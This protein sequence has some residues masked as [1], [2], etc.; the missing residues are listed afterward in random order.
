M[1]SD[2]TYRAATTLAR[3]DKSGEIHRSFTSHAAPPGVL[4][5]RR[6][7]LESQLLELDGQVHVDDRN[8]GRE[9][10]YDGGEIQDAAH[11]G[12]RERLADFLR[13]LPGY[14]HNP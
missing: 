6:L 10:Q 7:H 8:P 13:R 2:A 9:P 5:P 14:R 1:C 12:I 3:T 4:L 11:P